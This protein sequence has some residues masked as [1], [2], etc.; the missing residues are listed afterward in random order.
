MWVASKGEDCTQVCSTNNGYGGPVLHILG[1]LPIC[2]VC[3]VERGDGTGHEFGDHLEGGCRLHN[4]KRWCCAR[5][6][7]PGQ[8]RYGDYDDWRETLPT[9]HCNCLK[10]KG[11]GDKCIAPDMCVL[12][13]PFTLT[14]SVSVEGTVEPLDMSLLTCE[15]R[16]FENIV[17]Y[18]EAGREVY[19]RFND[20]YMALATDLAILQ[21]TLNAHCKV[22][23]RT[24]GIFDAKGYAQCGGALANPT[25]GTGNGKGKGKVPGTLD[26]SACA[27]AAKT[28]CPGQCGSGV[29]NST[30]GACPLCDGIPCRSGGSCALQR[31]SLPLPVRVYECTRLVG[32]VND[33]CTLGSKANVC[34]LAKEVGSLRTYLEDNLLPLLP[35]L[36]KAMDEMASKV[37]NGTANGTATEP[38]KKDI[39]ELQ[40]LINATF[41]S[42]GLNITEF[43][44]RLKKLISALA[45]PAVPKDIGKAGHRVKAQGVL[46][47]GDGP[48]KEYCEGFAAGK[49]FG[50]KV[51]L[52]A[53]R[54]AGN[55]T[56]QPCSCDKPAVELNCTGRK[57]GYV[58]AI[59]QILI[60]DSG[61]KGSDD[62]LEIYC[63]KGV[64]R[65][66]LSKEQCPWRND[67]A[68]KDTST[69][70]VISEDKPIAWNS[71]QG[72]D[73]G[74]PLGTQYKVGKVYCKR[75]VGGYK[76]AWTAV[77]VD[78]ECSCGGDGPTKPIVV[79]PK[80]Y[81]EVCPPSTCGTCRATAL[82]L[83]IEIANLD[84]Y[85]NAANEVVD[86]LATVDPA[87][88]FIKDGACL[89]YT[90]PG[91]DCASVCRRCYG[92]SAS[93]CQ[94]QAGVCVCEE[95]LTWHTTNVPCEAEDRGEGRRVLACCARMFNVTMALDYA[96]V[97]ANGTDECVPAAQGLA[98]PYFD[99]CQTASSDTGWCCFDGF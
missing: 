3:N 6:V 71:G 32:A 90:T 40:A 78:S 73:L 9:H 95:G 86:V 16:H 24:K 38:L 56:D 21:D 19:G 33:A 94:A 10:G 46:L 87:R 62:S 67:I 37:R 75:N 42:A 45:D 51:H 97:S 69:C 76:E 52:V 88:L 49:C 12:V 4:G 53:V 26:P 84:A 44:T 74:Q 60:H 96:R 20:F 91:M 72:F 31:A 22:C 47:S 11:G 14:G 15:P 28:A 17:E 54:G 25:N 8:C 93:H 81:P 43:Q 68:S 2:N 27:K 57:D 13:P 77:R 41:K 36:V 82:P 99:R 7:S 85:K 61:P 39:E 50:R 58:G 92:A 83:D 80:E 59:D 55:G 98:A 30:L 5:Q 64:V 23:E 35:G 70:V 65:L 34:E 48:W 29:K 79:P 18:L 63:R 1:D 66:C 89:T